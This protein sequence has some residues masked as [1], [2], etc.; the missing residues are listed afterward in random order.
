[1][2]IEIPFENGIDHRME[3]NMHQARNSQR[4]AAH[5]KGLVR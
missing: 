3:G 4:D 5:G 2:G 1:M